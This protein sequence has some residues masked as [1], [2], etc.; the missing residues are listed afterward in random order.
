MVIL[1]LTIANSCDGA[2]VFSKLCCLVDLAISLCSM[3]LFKIFCNVCVKEEEEEIKD[4][5]SVFEGKKGIYVLILK[6][7]FPSCRCVNS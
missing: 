5:R 7:L 1:R 4:W 2:C 6:I 3:F